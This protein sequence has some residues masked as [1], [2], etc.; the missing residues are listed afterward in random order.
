MSRIGVAIIVAVLLGV[1]VAI[2]GEKLSLWVSLVLLA[3][4]PLALHWSLGGRP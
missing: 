1:I 4:A 3:T 2:E